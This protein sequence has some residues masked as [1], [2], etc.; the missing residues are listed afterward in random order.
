MNCSDT[1]RISRSFPPAPPWE[2]AGAFSWLGERAQSVL[3]P[4]V[5]DSDEAKKKLRAG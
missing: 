2:T 1:H 4:I 5:D 3:P